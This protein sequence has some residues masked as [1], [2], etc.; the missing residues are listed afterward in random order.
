MRT[1]SSAITT[2]R[3][4]PPGVGWSLG[5]VTG[6]RLAAPRPPYAAS[7]SGW[8]RGGAGR[9]H[10][11]G[12][13]GLQEELYGLAFDADPTAGRGGRP[14]VRHRAGVAGAAP[15]GD[16]VPGLRHVDLHCPSPSA[17]KL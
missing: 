16:L 6:R 9:S 4:T 17:W 10:R 1:S 14:G 3:A 13:T 2:R 8:T 12:P 15:P 5:W 7:P 11:R